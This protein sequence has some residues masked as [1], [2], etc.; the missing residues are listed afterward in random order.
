MPPLSPLS[1]VELRSPQLIA[2]LDPSHGAEILDLVIAADGRQLLGRP[3]F[4]PRPP[5]AGD[6]DEDTWTASYR[7]GWQIATPNAGSPCELD[8]VHHGFHGRASVDPWQVLEQE[9]DRVALLWEGHGLRLRRTVALHGRRVTVGLEWTA[10]AHPTPLIAVEH[11]CFGHEVLDPAVVLE[12]HAHAHELSEADG[13]VRP[14]ANAPAWPQLRRLD[15]GVDA[16]H[17]LGLERPGALFLALSGWARGRAVLHNDA[18]RLRLVLEWDPARLPAAWLWHEVRATGGVWNGH[19]EL[20]GIEPAALSH[21]LGLARAVAE[22][23]AW[24]ARPGQT[25]RYE[26]N[27]T[28]EIPDR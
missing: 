7:G 3:P 18:R 12:A 20:L 10:L 19:A 25:D 6:L 1:L 26:V 17:L 5:Q 13:P 15:G 11:L 28:V 2:R 22:G 8:G 14:P 21:S 23:Q 16:A 24:W 27:L 9:P 4:I